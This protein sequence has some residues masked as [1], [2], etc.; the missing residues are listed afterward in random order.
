MGLFDFV[1]SL[2][3]KLGIDHFEEQERVKTLDDEASRLQAQTALREKL[4]QTL[5]AAVGALNL[6]ID[7]FAVSIKGE[8]V[9]LAGT[10][11]TQA[12]KE[13]AVMCVG[14]HAGVSHVDDAEFIVVTPEPPSVFHHVVK[15]D[16]LSLIAKRYYGIIMAFDEIAVANQPLINNVDEITPG[17]IIRVPPITGIS[18]TLKKGDT[19][20]AV[21]KTMYGDLMKYP[22]I[23][24]ANKAA[25]PDPDKVAPGLLLT[26][27][28]L[29]PLPV[30]STSPAVA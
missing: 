21:A 3:K 30:G 5:V 19:L 6:G 11:K 26:I 1:S 10:A 23:V 16:T 28:V 4:K 18:Y 14:N 17:W 8:V 20:S 2:G 22:V 13:K 7:G 24:D 29:H 25:I 27:P 9:H 12:D 15:G